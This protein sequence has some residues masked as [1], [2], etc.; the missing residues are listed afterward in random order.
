MKI[1]STFDVRAGLD[2]RQFS[3][4]VAAR[5]LGLRDQSGAGILMAGRTANTLL[6][7]S[8]SHPACGSSAPASSNLQAR[9]TSALESG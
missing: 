1:V 3:E 7:A 5:S 2:E 8:A 6:S 4:P 9:P